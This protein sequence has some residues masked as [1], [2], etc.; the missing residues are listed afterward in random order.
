[1]IKLWEKTPLYDET[2]GQEEPFLKVYPIE[3]K[4]KTGAVI[5]CPGGAYRHH[6]PHEKEPIARWINTLGMTSFVLTYRVAPYTYEAITSDVLR[7]IQQVRYNADK[8]NIDPDKIAVLG[9]S[10]GGHLA[11]SAAV[12]FSD[13]EIAGEKDEVSKM[14]PRPDAAV[15]CYPVI[16]GDE[17]ITH[18]DTFKRL[19]GE[20]SEDKKM[21]EFFSNEKQIKD[22]TPPTFIWHT[23]E[24]SIASALNSIAFAKGLRE[25]KIPFEL[26][27]FPHGGHGLTL[28]VEWGNDRISEWT[29]SCKNWFKTINFI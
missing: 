12:H 15:L 27:I 21:R 14:S 11:S 17:D 26:H 7:A 20:K 6:A 8:Y 25:K 23:A 22:D 1:M 28:G 3:K 16:S 13:F 5:V 19:L 29:Q 24:D 2:F 10:A 9:F 18:A 4:E